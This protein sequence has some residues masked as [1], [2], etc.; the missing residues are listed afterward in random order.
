M[1]FIT[2]LCCQSLYGWKPTILPNPTLREREDD[3]PSFSS[4][5]TLRNRPR[6]G[7]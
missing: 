7:L 2:S 1:G 5:L 4:L 3:E 6:P